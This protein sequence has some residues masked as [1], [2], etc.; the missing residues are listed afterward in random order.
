[1]ADARGP[2][3]HKLPYDALLA[4]LRS[5]T[6]LRVMADPSSATGYKLEP[7]PIPD[8]SNPPVW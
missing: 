3:F 7:G 1:M 8:W 2:S 5:L 4:K 6:N